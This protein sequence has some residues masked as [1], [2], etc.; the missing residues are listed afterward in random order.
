MGREQMKR[1]LALIL[2]FGLLPV[3]AAIVWVAVASLAASNPHEY[4]LVAPWILFIAWLYMPLTMAIAA[5]TI[6]A[7]NITPGDTTRK[8]RIAVLTF[9]IPILL[10]I[11]WVAMNALNRGALVAKV[12][13]EQRDVIEFVI[14]DSVLRQ[15]LGDDI[16]G[17]ISSVTTDRNSDAARVRFVYDESVRW[18]T[19]Y[20]VAVTSGSALVYAIVGV[21][22]D[23][24]GPHFTLKCIN[25]IALAQRDRGKGDCDQ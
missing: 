16:D 3:W 13:Q 8:T 10:G 22:R 11:G 5:L 23:R 12:E 18:P 15:R 6:A 19:K 4:W 14:H 9:A 17:L 1:A 20:E 21:T 25:S 7:Y 24:Q 2:G